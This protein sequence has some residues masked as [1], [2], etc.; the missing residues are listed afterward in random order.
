MDQ[1]L[2]RVG[3]FGWSQCLQLV[4]MS[5]VWAAAACQT[6]AS[7]FSSLDPLKTGFVQ[8]AKP[9]D[10]ACKDALAQRP[11]DVCSLPRDAWKWDHP[12]WSLVSE[13]DLACSGRWQLPCCEA[14]FFVGALLG[15]A[16]A[17]ASSKRGNGWR[18]LLY[19][20]C[21]LSCCASLLAATSPALW[22][23]ACSRL[24]T[25]MTVGSIGLA[26]YVL[27]TDPVGATWRGTAALLL[28]L[29]FSLGAC[30]AATLGWLLPSWRLLT[31]CCAL[32]PLACVASWS[33]T[34]ESPRW[35]LVRGRKGEATAALAA[36]AL[37]NR[38]RPLDLPLADVAV[39]LSG[40]QTGL[41]DLLRH[42][43][44][45][46]R[47]LL[48]GYCWFATS[49][50]YYGLALL[51]EPLSGVAGDARGDGGAYA[52]A[53][54]GFSYEIPGIAAAGLAAERVGRRA[55]LLVAL[56]QAGATLVAAAIAPGAARRALAVASRFG[57]AAAGATLF[58]S[59]PELF[60]ALLSN[61]GLLVGAYLARAGAVLAPLLS[62]TQLWLHSTRVPLL[63]A[64]GLLLAAAV[65]AAAMP[66]TL[67]GPACETIQDFNARGPATR[68]WL[69]S[70]SLRQ[71]LRGRLRRPASA[72]ELPPPLGQRM[73]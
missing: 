36:L 11:P 53:L 70:I 25:G 19:T 14:L 31:L 65:L 41:G 1:A 39:L 32:G 51:A 16:A 37:G 72:A 59:T 17:H 28:Q 73:S 45:R 22:V 67:G 47:L 10:Q 2:D 8:C 3:A 50:G 58:L 52:T 60:P 55:T 57:L 5:A 69:Q 43:G 40:A 38:C 30:A 44:L 24:F 61:Q 27:A 12:G 35:L 64:G 33:A 34:V 21:V 6:F 9:D 23:Y 13:F 26:S 29:A 20:S 62:L 63:V 4:L 49:L 46:R 48:V 18:R 42:P 7:T 66:E 68:G 54:T 71:L 15:C 56:L